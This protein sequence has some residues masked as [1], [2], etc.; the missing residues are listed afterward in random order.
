MGCRPIRAPRPSLSSVGVGTVQQVKF[1]SWL[2]WLLFA[3]IVSVAV[4]VLMGSRLGWQFDV[5]LSGSMEPVYHVGGV[6][7]F[8]PVDPST[9]KVGDIIAFNLPNMK[10]PISHRVIEVANEGVSTYFVTKGD[11]NNAPDPDKVL[12]EYVKGVGILYV[13]YAGRLLEVSNF[14]R[15]RIYVAGRGF[16]KAAIAIF[17]LGAVFIGLTLRDTIEGLFFPARRWRRDSLKKRRAL[18]LKRRKAFGA[19]GG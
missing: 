5:V 11:A 14:G 13:P 6:A 17:A 12:P 9:I 3:T 10:T 16:P 8:R 2:G 1:I 18:T 7:V 4:F 19:R 15:Q